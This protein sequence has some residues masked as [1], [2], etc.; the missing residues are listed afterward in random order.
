VVALPVSY[1]S[2]RIGFALMHIWSL[3]AREI[4]CFNTRMHPGCMVAAVPGPAWVVW[5]PV[6]PCRR[7]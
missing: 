2:E 6:N 4:T 3:F 7:G 5:V 1:M